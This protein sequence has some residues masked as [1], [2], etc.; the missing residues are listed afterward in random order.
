MK[1]TLILFFFLLTG[2]SLNA[3]SERDPENDHVRVTL[4][5]GSVVEGYVQTY[6]VDGKLFK[7][8]NTSFTMSP[9]PDGKDT[10]H[11]DAETVDA[12]DFVKPSSSDGRFDHLES[13]E[14]ANPST[15]SPKRTRRQFVYREGGNEFGTVFWWNGV[16]S[17]NMQL[18]KMNISTIYGLQLKGDSVVVPFMT[19]S[20]VS[21]NA[22]RIRYKKSY[23]GLV[24]YADKRVLK[25][26]KKLWTVLAEEPLLFLKICSDYL[27]ESQTW[28]D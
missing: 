2:L 16:D 3:Q 1:K 28:K 27:R 10:K 5:N 14:V 7:R 22:M 12:I 25:G 18:G 8:M 21:L 23:P 19:G 4:S 13:H 26:G 17:Q 11:F 20:V 6:W 24:E 9:K 15:F